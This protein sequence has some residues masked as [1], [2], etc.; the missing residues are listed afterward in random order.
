MSGNSTRIRYQK[1]GP[2][3]LRSRR[4]F[5]TAAGA[6]VY[7]ELNLDAKKYRIVDSVS[8]V[9][10]ATGGNTRNSSVL[11]IQSKRGLE[12]LGV[13]F[14]DESRN[15]GNGTSGPQA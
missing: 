2:G 4:Y 15:R 3:V 1:M 8:G 13:A 9:E 14:T 11:K 7:V 5:K 6:E 12:G 10:L